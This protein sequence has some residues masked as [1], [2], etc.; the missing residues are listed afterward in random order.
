MEPNGGKP[1]AKPTARWRT[2]LRLALVALFLVF[3]VVLLVKQWPQV[4]PLLRR[5]DPAAIVAAT[6]A[7]L[8]GVFGTFRAWRAVLADLGS[9]L[10]Q[11]AGMRVFF[12]GQLGKYLPGSVW[13]VL[14]QMELGRDYEVPERASAA[15]FVVFVLLILGT[16]LAL[17]VP[18]I[19][20]LSHGAH[21]PLS[22]WWALGA[23]VVAVVVATPPVLN[24]LLALALRLARRQP[25]PAP[26]SAAGI[27]RAAGWAVISWTCYGLHVFVLASALG[28]G[29]GA[30]L[31]LQSAGAFA[32][33]WCAG[34][35]LIAAPAGAGVRE[36]VLV[37]LLGAAIGRSQATVI[38][39]LSRLLFLLADLGWAAVSAALPRRSSR[40]TGRSPRGPRPRSPQSV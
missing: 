11:A 22:A 21:S 9:P 15:A 6:A 5:L 20:L 13:P 3:V 10:P 40:G 23:L 1:T 4:R 8:A 31:L 17:A 16:G 14:A 18:S 27:G 26:L 34:F 7:V 12:L 30:V 36:A 35:L 28:S 29:H 38:A 25:I 37:L 2:W 19:P 24:R 32:A 39:V 33:A